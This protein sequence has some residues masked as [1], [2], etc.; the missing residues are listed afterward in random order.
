MSHLARIV[1]NGTPYA[2]R[3][4]PTASGWVVMS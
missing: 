2:I 3:H 1:S 4:T